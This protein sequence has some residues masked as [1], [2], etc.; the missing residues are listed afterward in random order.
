M[1]EQAVQ[2]MMAVLPDRLH[3]HQRR[4]R[5]QLAEDFHAVLLAVDESVLLHRVAGMPAAY[6]AAFA[7]DG[8]HHSLFGLR[9]RRPALLVGR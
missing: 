3:H 5:R 1:G 8:V 9:L 4:I 6:V 7:A 2:N